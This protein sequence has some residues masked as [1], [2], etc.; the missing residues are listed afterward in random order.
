MT[1]LVKFFA[2]QQ[3]PWLIIFQVGKV[4]KMLFRK[5]KNDAKYFFFNVLK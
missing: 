3:V 5:G 2:R 4:A 1:L